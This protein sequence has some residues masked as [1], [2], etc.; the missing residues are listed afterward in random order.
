M[1]LVRPLVWEQILEVLLHPVHAGLLEPF[2]P[3]QALQIGSGET[4]PVESSHPA[5]EHREQ[6]HGPVLSSGSFSKIDL[7]HVV[8]LLLL[9]CPQTETYGV[10]G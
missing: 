9:Y 5:L 6:G 7:L 10:S 4:K 2:Q 1:E 8:A 3:E